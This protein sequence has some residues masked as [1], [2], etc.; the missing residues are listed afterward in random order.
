MIV[1]QFTLIGKISAMDVVPTGV[2]ITLSDAGPIKCRAAAEIRDPE[3]L[4]IVKSAAGFK[5]GDTVSLTG[6]SELDEKIGAMVLIVGKAGA[7]R[8]ATAPKPSLPTP[9]AKVVNTPPRTA[10]A[11]H[12]SSMLDQDIPF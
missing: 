3:L 12:G 4:A 5:Q 6:L 9:V 1:N 2:R 8:I 7:I 11:A 10:M